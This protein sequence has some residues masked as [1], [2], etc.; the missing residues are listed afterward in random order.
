[1][2]MNTPDILKL[3]NWSEPKEVQTK[4]GPRIL[5]KAEPTDTFSAAWKAHKDEIKAL[6]AGF[7]KNMYGN[8]ELTW[9]QELSAE[10]Q[11][12]RKESIEASR[13]TS[14]DIDLPH[15]PG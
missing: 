6:G 2:S 1:M 11:N 8:W 10:I 5:R 12:K 9:W 3:A 15:P 13:A 14:A 7:G 4:N